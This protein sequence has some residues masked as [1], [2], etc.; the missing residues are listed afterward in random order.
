[1]E[2]NKMFRH[3]FQVILSGVLSFSLANCGETSR[4]TEMPK[5]TIESQALIE[6]KQETS[7]ENNINPSKTSV[8]TPGSPL[9]TSLDDSEFVKKAFAFLEGNKEH[10]K[11]ANPRTEFV[12]EGEINENGWCTVI[13]DQVN[14]GVKVENGY[15]SVNFRHNGPLSFNNIIGF[16]D[17]EARKINTSPAIGEEQAERIALAD[18]KHKDTKPEISS[19]ELLIGRIDGDLRLFWSVGLINGGGVGSWNYRVDAQTGKILTVEP[20]VLID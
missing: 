3:T 2:A 6:K 4:K 20:A 12:V 14:N 8:V 18:S 5:A 16:Y 11:I 7:F 15:F 17:P 1:M 9:S 13:L 19:I 10:Y